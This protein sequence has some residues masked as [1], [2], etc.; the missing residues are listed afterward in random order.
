M[1]TIIVLISLFFLG[2]QVAYA[3]SGN[4]NSSGCH[5]SKRE[6][7]HCHGSSYSP[8]SYSSGSNDE[9]AGMAAILLVGA[10]A[11]G[12][13]SAVNALSDNNDSA[14]T[15]NIGSIPK[16]DTANDEM[17]DP[18]DIKYTQNS[19]NTQ[20]NDEI[21]SYIPIEKIEDKKLSVIERLNQKIENDNKIN[22]NNIKIKELFGVHI[23]ENIAINNFNKVGNLYQ[24]NISDNRLGFDKHY[25][26]M[27]DQKVTSILASKSVDVAVCENEKAKFKGIIENSFG[28]QYKI[29][30]SQSAYLLTYESFMLMV[31]C[32][33]NKLSFVVK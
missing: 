4:K 24:I 20:S 26:N 16:E 7:Y 2:N 1:K 10:I 14:D 3:S 25:F 8:S 18:N 31:S 6:G 17:L 28:T 12:V 22:S 15:K 21:N 13:S 5:S 30:L 11:V 19:E 9:L 32:Q 33:D 29:T 23:G 27:K